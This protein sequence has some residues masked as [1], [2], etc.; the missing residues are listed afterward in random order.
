M[1]TSTFRGKTIFLV[2]TGAE[3]IDTI[4]SIATA[5]QHEG[6]NLH[7]FLTAAGA[8]I[9]GDDT[10]NRLRQSRDVRQDFDWSKSLAQ[11]PEEDLI[12]VAPCSFNSMVKIAQGMA[13]NL[14]L[15]IT[16]SGIGLGKKVVLAPACEE[17]WGHPLTNKAVATLKSWNVTFV[18]PR[19]ADDQFVMADPKEIIRITCDLLQKER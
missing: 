11:L 14:A 12:L 17:F 8:Q 7:I 10:V 13:D 9:L 16:T 1:S 18:D 2:A 4:E 6:V 5:L 19:K 15:S 3:R